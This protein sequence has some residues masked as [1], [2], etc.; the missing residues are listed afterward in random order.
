MEVAEIVQGYKALEDIAKQRKAIYAER[1]RSLD[2]TQR[3]IEQIDSQ[4]LEQLAL[5]DTYTKSMETLKQML[6]DLSL[7]RLKGIE[8]FLNYAMSN[9][10][11]DKNYSVEFEIGEFRGAKTLDIY[12]IDRKQETNADGDVVEEVIKANIKDSVGGGVRTVVGFML[13]VFF[14]LLNGLRPIMFMDE[15]LSMLSSA[16]L[17][18]FYGLV[19]M[20]CEKHGLSLLLITHDA[21][22]YS[23][24][25]RIYKVVDGEVKISVENN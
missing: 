14:I 15:S 13:Q 11:F 16:Y 22:F 25:R 20:L 21:R 17:E 1:E 9:V 5:K 7:G 19:D 23:V 2:R 3:E 12:L 6:D 4:V 8:S 24:A 10:F 18:K